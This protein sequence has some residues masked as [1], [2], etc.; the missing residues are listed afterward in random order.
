MEGRREGKRE[1]SHSDCWYKYLIGQYALLR[2]ELLSGMS[3]CGRGWAGGN[4]GWP[5]N[6]FKH[7]AFAFLLTIK[8]AD[9]M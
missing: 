4:H 5:M 6:Q 2:F 1:E 8:G 9:S 3:T 7:F